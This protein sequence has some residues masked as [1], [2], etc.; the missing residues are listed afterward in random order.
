MYLDIALLQHLGKAL[1]NTLVV[2]GQDGV[3]RGQQHEFQVFR[4]S[5]QGLEFVAQAVLHGQDQ[6]H[7]A[8][9]RAHHGNRHAAPVHRPLAGFVQQGQ[10]A[11]V[12][13]CNGL[14][15][16]GQALS[17]FNLTHLRG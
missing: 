11:L 5:A 14:D 17:A 4:V 10:P 13:L 9:A 7:T 2:R 6:F 16:H 15:R 12:E 8:R 1:A 3:A